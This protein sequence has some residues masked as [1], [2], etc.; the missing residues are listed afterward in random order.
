M[1]LMDVIKFGLIKS[2]AAAK[3]WAAGLIDC[4]HEDQ[5][6]GELNEILGLSTREYQAWTTGGISLLTIARWHKTSHPPLDVSKP[7][8]KLSGRPPAEVA[9]YLAQ[10]T[11][12]KPRT[13][14]STSARQV[15]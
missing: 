15:P 7:W 9:G 6:P 8:F 5:I 2:D 14:R 4:W 3:K 12:A 10:N 1:T 13:R 11:L